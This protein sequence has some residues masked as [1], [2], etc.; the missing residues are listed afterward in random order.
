LA[1]EK[2]SETEAKKLKTHFIYA[3][4]HFYNDRKDRLLVSFIM[5]AMKKYKLKSVMV[6][7]IVM[8]RQNLITRE[9]MENYCKGN[10]EESKLSVNDDLES[11]FED[12][13]LGKEPDDGALTYFLPKLTKKELELVKIK[14]ANYLKTF[15]YRIQHLNPDVNEAEMKLSVSDSKFVDGWCWRKTFTIENPSQ[16]NPNLNFTY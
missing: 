2:N 4:L 1:L 5:K 8:S 12:I 7:T 14:D 10:D 6:T 3:G 16:N 9:K 11:L 15:T 13:R